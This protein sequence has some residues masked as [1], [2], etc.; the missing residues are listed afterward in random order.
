MLVKAR[1][2][3]NSLTWAQ[4]VGVRVVYLEPGLFIGR[5]R[6]RLEELGLA[7]AEGKILGPILKTSLVQADGRSNVNPSTYPAIAQ[8]VEGASLNP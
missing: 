3:F 6:R 7:D 5:L 8:M 4:R 2:E 1:A